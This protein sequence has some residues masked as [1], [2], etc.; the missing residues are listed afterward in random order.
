MCTQQFRFKKTR[1]SGF[2]FTSP[3]GIICIRRSPPGTRSRSLCVT[4]YTRNLFFLY[5]YIL[6]NILFSP[7]LTMASVQDGVHFLVP[8]SGNRIYIYKRTHTIDDGRRHRRR[9]D[10]LMSRTSVGI[11]RNSLCI[12]HATGHCV[13][14]TS[15]LQSMWCMEH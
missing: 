4:R 15:Y 8:A 5:I 1:S 13:L 2:Q 7:G 12:N 6:F 14:L 10:A 11:D 9:R 3:A